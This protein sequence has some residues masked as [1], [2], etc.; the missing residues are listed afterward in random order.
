MN[1]KI[2]LDMLDLEDYPRDMLKYLKNY[3]FHF[4]KAAC[5]DAVKKLRRR[6]P[7]TGKN[8]PIDVKSK[9][10]IEQILTRLNIKL[11]RNT[12]YDF[13]WVYNMLLSDFWKSGIDDEIHLAK[14]TKDVI[15]DPDQRDGFI[16][17]RW[18]S[19]RM[20]NG[21]PIEWADLI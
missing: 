14:A 1:D 10:E 15:D 9:D 18:I 20:F 13:V 17:N 3:G 2:N 5:E 6:N 11:E 19:D 8:E 21:E 16:F 7:A 12:L 4:N